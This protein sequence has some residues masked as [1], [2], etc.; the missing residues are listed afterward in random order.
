MRNPLS[1]AKEQMTE[2]TGAQMFDQFRPQ[3]QALSQVVAER[4]R[5]QL[6]LAQRLAEASDADISVDELPDAEERA[7]QLETMAERASQA[8]L[9][10][11]YFGEFVPDHLDNP[12][13]AQ[14]YADLND[15]EWQAQKQSWAENYRSTSPEAEAYS[16]DELAALHVENTFGVPLDEFEANVVDFRPGEAIQ[17]VLTTNLRTVEA[18]MTAVAEDME[19]SA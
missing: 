8:D 14:A 17:D 12:D 9:V 11:W 18:V 19:G 5:A 3:M 13:R 4:E 16:D 2:A 6:Q 10:G 15:D 1:A 7:A